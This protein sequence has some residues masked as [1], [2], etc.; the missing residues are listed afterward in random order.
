MLILNQKTVNLFM[1]TRPTTNEL[2]HKLKA[3]T[4]AIQEKR[5][6]FANHPKIV[7]EL[8]G[9]N[10]DDSLEVWDLILDLLKEVKSDHYAGGHPPQPSNEKTIAGKDLWAFTWESTKLGKKMY[11]KF[12]LKDDVFYYVSL[13]ESRFPLKS[14]EVVK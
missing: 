4:R 13:H 14:K 8:E 5:V 2:L 3:A 1:Q 12:A 11:L 10:I 9:L 6:R 7:G